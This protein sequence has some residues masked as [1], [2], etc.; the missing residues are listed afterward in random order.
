MEPTD[1]ATPELPRY[2]QKAQR[3]YDMMTGML[4]NVLEAF[5]DTPPGESDKRSA[6]DIV[7]TIKIHGRVL[8][9]LIEHE[10]DLAKRT[11]RI[12]RPGPSPADGGGDLDLDAARRD[13]TAEIIRVLDARRNRGGGGEPG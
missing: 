10:A 4:M 13:I 6:T 11:S 9:T 2:I 8:T 7:D 1:P 12:E 3:S 5:A